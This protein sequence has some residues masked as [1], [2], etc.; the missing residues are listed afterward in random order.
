MSKNPPIGAPRMK[1]CVD[2]GSAFTAFSHKPVRCVICQEKRN[3]V[4]QAANQREHYQQKRERQRLYRQKQR[5]DQTLSRRARGPHGRLVLVMDPSGDYSLGAKF[6]YIA[7][8][9]CG[10]MTT[11]YDAWAVGTRWSD[12]R[13]VFEYQTYGKPIV[14]VL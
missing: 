11:N 3:R 5:E 12:G 9:G 6:D 14:R 1:T 2:C 7:L 10:Y 13:H 4:M 8:P